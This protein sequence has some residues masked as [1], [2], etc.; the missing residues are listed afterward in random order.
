[1][2]DQNQNIGMAFRAIA[3]EHP[4]LP[5]II[6]P[7][8][9]L[10]YAKLW[11]LSA[12]FARQMQR[13][14]VDRDSVISMRADDPSIVTAALIASSL[15]GARFAQDVGDRDV[16][17]FISITHSFLTRAANEADPDN[18]IEIDA[19]WSPAS[20]L[21]DDIGDFPGYVDPDADWLIVH[22][23]GTTG[24]PKFMGLSQKV[25]FERSAA[26]KADFV[27]QTR[28]A[29]LFPATSRPFFARICAAL[30]NGCTLL[31]GREPA[32]LQRESVR[33][34]SASHA[35]IASLLAD[36][37]LTPKIPLLE[38]SG[39]PMTPELAQRLLRSFNTVADV[40]G[41]SETNKT[42][43]N[44][45][46]LDRDGQVR[47][48]GQPLDSLVEIVT[49]DG[50]PIGPEQKGQ[51]RIRNPYL[52]RG[53]LQNEEATLAAFKDGWFYPGD[54]ASWGA[55]GEL[56]VRERDDD[57]VNFAGFKVHALAI[58][59]VLRGVDGIRD[60]A[61]FMNPKPG[62]KAELFAFVVLDENTNKLQLT[63]T[64]KY[65]CGETFGKAFVPRI[66]REVAGIPRLSNSHPDRTA[67]AALILSVGAAAAS[68]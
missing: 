4:D 22:T 5:A 14:G 7:D 9:E 39:A 16:S 18:R 40:Y 50:L 8:I 33:M 58:D 54:I 30:L 6:F 41:A 24:Y 26:V 68:A 34:I 49:P 10:S 12:A 67:C 11:R 1:M 45:L 25:V 56:I 59:A 43:V 3:A 15:L 23:S 28:F 27:P 17:A 66:I 51:V 20:V 29:C 42:F 48:K 37:D 35:Q 36:S 46:T 44:I 63:A 52:A 53:Y 55:S 32:F 62:A 47:T 38:I 19:S 2:V 65:R 61:C 31:A 64:A 13:H 21:T 57:V 60:A